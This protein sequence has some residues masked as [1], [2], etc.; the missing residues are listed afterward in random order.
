MQALEQ[1]SKLLILYPPPE[2]WIQRETLYNNRE[3]LDL[4]KRE[5]VDYHLCQDCID[6]L[7]IQE[8]LDSPW[9]VER[10]AGYD[11]YG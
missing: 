7:G 3:V 10:Q 2:G 5:V 4:V 1:F 9:D 11:Y 6:K 8:F